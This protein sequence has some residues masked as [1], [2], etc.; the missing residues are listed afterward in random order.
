MRAGDLG[1]AGDAGGG[2]GQ[3]RGKAPQGTVGVHHAARPQHAADLL[4]VAAHRLG[5]ARDRGG[6]LV[7]GRQ[8]QRP[9]HRAPA[10]MLPGSSWASM[11]SAALGTPAAPLASIFRDLDAVS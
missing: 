2:L 9:A 11:A 6:Q 10:V 8:Q 4:Q 5:D 1:Q 3:E 7:P